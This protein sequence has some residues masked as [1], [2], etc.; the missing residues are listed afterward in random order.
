M[1]NILL[2]VIA[3]FLLFPSCGEDTVDQQTPVGTVLFSM[4][5]LSVW[6]NPGSGNGNNSITYEQTIQASSLKVEYFVETNV[7]SLHSEAWVRDSSNGSPPHLVEQYIYWYSDS[8]YS[9]SMDVPYQPFHIK[10]EV[11]LHTY[12]SVIPHYI[13]LKNIKVTKQ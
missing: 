12:S 9:Y 11:R 4:D 8:L 2:I 1:K 5:S 6:L 3:A 13:R 10:L 7:D